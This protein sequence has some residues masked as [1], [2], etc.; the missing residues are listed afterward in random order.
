MTLLVAGGVTVGAAK[1]V[2]NIS[3]DPAP[4]AVIAAPAAPSPTGSWC[5]PL[6]IILA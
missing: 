3:P 5:H 4:P 1:I 6:K 2:T